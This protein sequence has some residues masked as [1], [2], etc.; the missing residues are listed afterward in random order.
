M[1]VPVAVIAVAAITGGWLLQRGVDRADN[2]YVKVRLF[3]EVVDRVES[4]FVDE[5]APDRLY[6]S[7]IDGIL[8]DLD[9]PYSSF[10]EAEDFEDLRIRGIEGDYGGV[11]LEVVERNGMVTVVSPMSG[12]PGDRAGIRAGDQFF[13]I[14]GVAADTMTTDQAVVLLRGKPGTEVHVKML[15]PGVDEPVP[16]TLSREVIQLKAVPFAVMLDDDVAYVPFQSVLESSSTEIQTAL[17]SLRGEGMKRLVLDLRGNPGG[18]LDQGIAV[19]D[20]FLDRGLAIV[21]TRGRSPD[22]NAVYSAS[23]SDR[24]PGLPMVVLIDG[25]SASASEI[26]AGALQDHDRA[27]LLGQS[28]FGKGLVQS[29]YRLSGGSVLRLTTARWYTPVGRSINKDPDVRFNGAHGALSMN[30]QLSTGSDLQ[31]RP[32]YASPA[33]RT[34]FGGGGIAPDVFVTPDTLTQAEEA[35]VRSVYRQAGAFNQA[36]FNYAVRY[37][38]EHPGLEW[39][40]SLS[41]S[42]LADFN[43]ALPAWD[44]EVDAADLRA[45]R[46]FIDYQLEREIALQAWGEQGEFIHAWRTDR[47]LTAAL[48]LLRGI[49]SPDALLAEVPPP[50]VPPADASTGETP[51]N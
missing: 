35:A 42:E 21:E 47:Q 25:G 34:L 20:L 38:Q 19:S 22:Q 39:N 40:F 18:V 27:V 15:R 33:G 13:E 6:S 28:T 49:D 11:G 23:S 17:D 37:V 44:V 1:I 7:A 51:G 16:F 36:I 48:D 24:Y 4:S 2:V 3:Q 29:L 9:D 5:V 30:G 10:M 26:V 41:E 45:A 8:E 31:G 12:G 43:R 14:D 46:R 50:V 32:T